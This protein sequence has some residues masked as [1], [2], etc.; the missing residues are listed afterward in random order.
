M[1]LVLLAPLVGLF[2]VLSLARWEEVV[3]GDKTTSPVETHVLT[4]EDATQQAQDRAE[5]VVVNRRFTGQFGTH[6]TKVPCSGVRQRRSLDARKQ[7]LPD[8]WR[9]HACVSGRSDRDPQRAR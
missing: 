2:L 9:N 5:V 3:L 6:V 7:Q 8:R 1:L 4:R